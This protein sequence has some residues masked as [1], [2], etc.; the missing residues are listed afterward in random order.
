[1]KFTP[2]ALALASASFVLASPAAAQYGMPAPKAPPQ[3]P[4]KATEDAPQSDQKGPSVSNAARKEI[5]ELKTAVDNKDTANIPA[6][7][8]AAKAKAKT[9]DDNYAIAQLQLRAAIDAQNYDDALLSVDAMAAS[10]VVPASQLNNIYSGLGIKFFEAKQYDKAT[11]A[12]QKVLQVDPNNSDVIVEMARV[13]MAQGN[14]AGAY[15]S[16]KKAIAVKAAAGQKADASW[17][18]AALSTA[19]TGKLPAVDEAGRAWLTAYPSKANW[20][21]TLRVYLR[22]H[23]MSP[24]AGVDVSRLMFATGSMKEANDYYRLAS[25]V[26]TAF[27]GEAKAVLDHGAAAGIVKVADSEIAPIYQASVSKSQGDRASLEGSAKAAIASGQASRIVRNADAYYGY[28]DYA[29]A[30]ELY[31]TA[32]GK[33]GADAN[34]INLRLG[35]SLA[36]A[37]DKAGATAALSSVTGP[38]AGI[39]QLWLIY[40]NNP[41]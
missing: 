36:R 21:E 22:S 16:L 33:T 14:N 15:A 20:N 6:K 18:K 1:M 37:G 7:L 8:A 30:A 27:P 31:R 26:F 19:Y 5:I 41:A 10:G 4:Q 40:V 29:K 9:K 12:Y 32:L 39:A 24:A 38:N 13:Q 25:A 35:M 34:L 3:V 23:N 17:Y 28:G 11:G 2:F